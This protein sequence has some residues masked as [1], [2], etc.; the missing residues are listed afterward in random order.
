MADAKLKRVLGLG[1]CVFFAVGVIVGAGIYAVIGEAAAFAG[2]LL[3][4]AFLGAAATA[5]LTA[6]AY[7][8]LVAMYPRSGGEYEDARAAIGERLAVALGLLMALNGVVS[9][10]TIALAFAGY[11]AQLVTVPLLVAVAGVVLVLAAV[12]T[13]GIRHSSVTNIILTTLEIGGLVFVV[14]AAAPAIGRVDLL[15]WPVEGVTGLC[16]AAALSFFAFIGFEDV[17]KLAEETRAPE[18]TI[19][20]ALLIATAIVTVI[21][22]V[23]AVAAISS[24]PASELRGGHS[25]MAA[26]VGP[27][28][29]RTGVIVISVLALF[30]TANSILSNMMGS[31]RVLLGMGRERPRMRA[32]GKVA[33]RTGTPVRALLLVAGLMIAFSLIGDLKTVAL[34]SNLF[35]FSTFILVHACVIT[36]RIK[37]PDLPRPFRVPGSVKG[38]PALSVLAVLM[39]LILL[40]F[41]IR[42]LLVG[43]HA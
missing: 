37:Q 15:A 29:G 17:V 27:H 2:N 41:C 31:S 26:I 22:L 33:R 40:G 38:V 1:E 39:L 19:P 36:L 5:A 28:Y 8:E 42:G 21:Y 24:V 35:I 10:S 20:R 16:T 25:P 23:V 18:R 6:L 32:L 14:V 7:A 9:G 12:N 13:A 11:L 4:L 34:T 43:G 3:W 30:S